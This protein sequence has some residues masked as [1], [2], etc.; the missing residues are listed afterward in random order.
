V[1]WVKVLYPEKRTVYI[2][3]TPLGSTNTK[4]CVGE[5]ATHVFHLGEPV[6]YKPKSMR[7]R[8]AGTSRRDPLVLRFER[9]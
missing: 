7:R 3:D 1:N 9:I 6:D 5:D 2:G 4:Q 8:A